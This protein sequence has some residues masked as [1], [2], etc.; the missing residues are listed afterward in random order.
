MS[1]RV[2]TG[3]TEYVGV[4]TMVI[5]MPIDENCNDGA[6]PILKKKGVRRTATGYP[7]DWA[8]GSFSP[9]DKQTIHFTISNGGRLLEITLHPSKIMDNKNSTLCNG[10]LVHGAVAWTIKQLLSLCRPIWTINYNTGEELNDPRD[11]PSNW[12]DHVSISRLDLARDI[13]DDKYGFYP[14]MLQHVEKKNYPNDFLYRN[15]GKINTLNYGSSA[16][17][18]TNFYNKSAAPNHDIPDGW[19]RFE[20]Q[21]RRPYLVNVGI[22]TLSDIS[23]AKVETIL[24]DRWED[25]RLGTPISVESA[26]AEFFKGV[27]ENESPSIAITMLGIATALEHGLDV[28]MNARTISN[29]KKIARRYGFNLGQSIS[30][31]GTKLITADFATGKVI[32]VDTTIAA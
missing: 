19:N 11:W 20:I 16:R 25:G 29:Y 2:F 13:Y 5:R 7:L 27:A 1:H 6:S 14:G 3:H 15:S 31:M 32:E 24:W 8:T 12:T 9:D 30:E 18:R 26:L 4:D 17:I 28:P 10:D 22:D 23:Q 21:A